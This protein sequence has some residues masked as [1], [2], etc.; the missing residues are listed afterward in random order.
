M[1]HECTVCRPS[2]PP[3]SI[4]LCSQKPPWTP[5]ARPWHRWPR[6]SHP[7][8]PRE[9]K[10][11]LLAL[12]QTLD[13]PSIFPF[14]RRL[15]PHHVRPTPLS[16]RLRRSRGHRASLPSG[17]SLAAA[18]RPSSSSTPLHRARGAATP[19]P[20]LLLLLR[21]PTSAASIRRL[22]RLSEPTTPTPSLDPHHPPTT[23]TPLS[24][25]GAP[26]CAPLCFPFLQLLVFVAVRTTPCT[27]VVVV[28]D[29]VRPEE[30]QGRCRASGAPRRRV[31]RMRSRI[32]ARP[33]ESN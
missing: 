27:T 8:V 20:R 23:P 26:M 25:P 28:V 22:R 33:L 1:G 19:L 18:P 5:G 10:R 11:P 9:D 21:S 7:P 17:G 32:H 4:F 15:L 2:P 31:C 13:A 12:E 3:I 29:G 6:G 16:P 24:H 14:S 30:N